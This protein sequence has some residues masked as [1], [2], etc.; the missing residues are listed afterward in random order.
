MTRA[1]PLF[2]I[3]EHLI[4]LDKGMENLEL[5]IEKHYTLDVCKSSQERAAIYDV[6]LEE[7]KRRS[8]ELCFIDEIPSSGEGLKRFTDMWN[9]LAT[10]LE[11]ESYLAEVEQI[12]SD[13]MRN[14]LS[15]EIHPLK[16][17]ALAERLA[18]RFEASAAADSCPHSFSDALREAAEEARVIALVVVVLGGAKE[19]ET[20]HHE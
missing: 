6:A 17:K 9:Q 12:V 11:Q 13:S 16:R 18:D 4:A 5:R 20:T 14:I 1:L 2:S 7:I 10:T 15:P 3:E 8:N 19:A